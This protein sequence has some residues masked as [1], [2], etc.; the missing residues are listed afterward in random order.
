MIH[1][2]AIGLFYAALFFIL[3]AWLGPEKSDL[4]RW[5]NGGT[6]VAHSGWTTATGWFGSKPVTGGMTA[7]TSPAPEA[8]STLSQAPSAPPFATLAAAR[9]AYAKG[10][11]DTAISIYD[12]LQRAEPGN[13]AARGEMANVLFNVGR[14]QEAAEIYFTVATQWLAQGERDKAR[15]L[16]PAIRRGSPSHADEL[17]RLLGVK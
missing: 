11:I 2:I 9:A 15:A 13:L 14:L 7:D 4:A 8:V 17:N 12:A 10:D 3:G 6:A 1:R 5:W 16:E